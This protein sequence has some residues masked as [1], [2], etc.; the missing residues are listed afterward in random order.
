MGGCFWNRLSKDGDYWWA[1][2]TALFYNM[3]EILAFAKKLSLLEKDST[4]RS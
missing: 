2:R 3:R 1:V 4:P